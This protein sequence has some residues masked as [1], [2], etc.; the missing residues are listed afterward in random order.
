MSLPASSVRNKVPASPTRRRRWPRYGA[1]ILFAGFLFVYFAPSIVLRSRVRNWLL[2]KLSPDLATQIH[3]DGISSGWWTPIELRGVR[4]AS[5]SVEVLAESIRFD[6]TLLELMRDW[7]HL[8]AIRVTSPQVTL[9]ASVEPVAMVD[10]AHADASRGNSNSA[11]PDR[12]TIASR[13]NLPVSADIHVTGGSLYVANSQAGRTCLAR[14]VT[15]DLNAARDSDRLT[16]RLFART[17]DPR[18]TAHVSAH[19]TVR[20]PCRTMFADLLASH[21]ELVGVNADVVEHLLSAAGVSRTI[22]E[23]VQ[24]TD[25]PRVSGTVSGS[26]DLRAVDQD[27]VEVRANFEVQDFG[28]TEPVRQL[29]LHEPTISVSVVARLSGDGIHLD[30]T[31]VA[32]GGLIIDAAGAIQDYAGEAR[33][34]LAGSLLCDWQDL[35]PRLRHVLPDEI[36]I[37]GKGRRPWRLSGPLRGGAWSELAPRLRL[38]AGL[39]VESLRV[40]DFEFGPSELAAHFDNGSVRFDPIECTFQDGQVRAQPSIVFSQGIPVLQLDAGRVIDQVAL[41]PRLCE[42]ILRYVDPLAAISRN[43]Q[44]HLS[45]DIDELQIPLTSDGLARGSIVGRVALDDVQFSPQESLRQILAAAGIAAQ[46]KSIRTSQQIE[47]RLSDGRVHHAGLAL[48][49]GTEQV[50]LDGWVGLDQTINIRISLPVTE[51]MLGKDKRLYRLLRGQRIELPVTG[52]LDN[53]R[54]TDE[55]LARNIHRLVQAALRE[56][57]GDDPLRGLLRRALK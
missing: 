10:E 37:A 8:G 23:R 32:A 54:V 48:P 31:R 2:N 19:G 35:G 3:V 6:R 55:A 29:E 41:D 40:C 39:Y 30:S 38:D 17:G 57:L 27:S 51:E 12:T 28:I 34:D 1:V 25:S 7:R 13:T 44:G 47:V 11:A 24:R 9:E 33:T 20:W 5:G 16:F 26:A 15:F 4:Y 50:T 18:A 14:S 49:I 53:P 52:T 42:W 45:L 46:G 21:V 22:A 43:L 56:N 36:Q